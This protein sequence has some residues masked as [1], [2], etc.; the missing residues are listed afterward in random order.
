[1]SIAATRLPGGRLKDPNLKLL[2]GPIFILL[3]MAMLILPLPPWANQR[4]RCNSG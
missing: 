4:R 2:T 3:V 1:M